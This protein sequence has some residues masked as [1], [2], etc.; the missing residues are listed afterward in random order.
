VQVVAPTHLSVDDFE[1]LDQNA[2]R[3]VGRVDNRQRLKQPVCS[4]LFVAMSITPEHGHRQG[5]TDPPRHTESSKQ[6]EVWRYTCTTLNISESWAY[7]FGGSRD[8]ID[9]VIIDLARNMI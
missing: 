4:A 1:W 5:V 6:E 8:V 3:Q 2:G 9:H 7:L